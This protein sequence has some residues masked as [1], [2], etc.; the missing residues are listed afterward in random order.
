MKDSVP[1]SKFCKRIHMLGICGTGMGTLAAMLQEAGCQ[2]QGS[3]QDIYPP[4]S[5]FLR[6]RGIA[7]NQGYALENLQPLP[8]LVIIG[9]VIRRDN[10]EAQAVL[11]QGLPYCSMPQA[12]SRFFLEGRL[13]VVVAGTHGKTTTTTFLAWLLTTAGMDPGCLVGGIMSNWQQS[14]RLGNGPYFVVEGDEYDTAFFDKGPKFLHYRPHVCILTSVEFDHADIFADLQAVK[15]AFSQLVSLI[16]PQGILVANA[17]DPNVRELQ[18]EAVCKVVTYGIRE[19]ADYMASKILCTQGRTNFLVSGPSDLQIQLGSSLPGRHNV[20]NVLAAIAVAHEL[21]VAA[22]AMVEALST[23]K[24]VRRRQEVRARV[25]GITIIDDFAHHPT[26]VNATVRALQQYYP[27]HR[28]WAIFEPR[29]NSSRRG[30]F[31][32]AYAEAFDAAHMVLLKEPPG[33]ESIPAAE[34][35][36]VEKLAAAIGKRGVEAHHFA[37]AD[38]ILHFIS[39]RAEPGDVLLLMSTGSFDNLHQRIIEVLQCR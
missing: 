19:Q 20:S 1:T 24:G 28:L 15:Q 30:V 22:A 37:D 21:E 6:A 10:P 14:Y 25:D 16:P 26:A 17:D 29:T 3:D 18:K 12:V 7:I 36:S 35:L 8:D 9:N 32:Q 13:P 39:S 33:L 23:F 27:G 34:R 2:V 31:Q 5:T 4:M 38:A 11:E